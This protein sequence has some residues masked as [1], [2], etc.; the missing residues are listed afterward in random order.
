MVRSLK[1]N[2]LPISAGAHPSFPSAEIEGDL[3]SL[4]K[5][6]VKPV[7]VFNGITP[8][9]YE[10]PF[11][12]DEPKAWRRASAWENYEQ[13]RV[14]PQAQ[15]E[16]AASAPVV[17]ADVMRMVHRL[18]KQRSVEFVVAPYLAWAQLVYLERHDRAY[19]HSMYGSNELFMFDGVDRV[20]LNID[21]ASS[22]ISFA[23]KTSILA[24]LVVTHDQFLDIAIFA[25]FEGSPT[26]PPLAT[27][28]RD[29]SFQHVVG[30]IK[31]RASGVAAVTAYK[32]YPPVFSYVD[33]FAR[34]K[35]MI[36]Y[37]LVLVAQEGRVLPLPLVLPPPAFPPTSL[38]TTAADVPSDLSE[39]FS[40]HFP[41]EVYYQLF[42][43]LIGPPVLNP[44]ASGYLIESTPLCGSTPEYE[45]YLKNL[46][47]PTQSPRCVAT[48]LVSSVLSPFW[49]K[50]PVVR[51]FFP[52]S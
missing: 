19:V 27:E 29:F 52:P 38:I 9:D 18:F 23:S 16:F 24:D 43:G 39:I 11:G 15:Q 20:I 4:E 12:A 8:K 14:F 22:T 51:A 34:A 50:R 47:E 2:V 1:G 25:G 26:F 31:A 42:R 41:D 30:L 6:G 7:F 28:P 10:R 13:G 45:V 46:T 40:P 37:A 48:A 49:A 17:P 5:A 35:C 44:L 33:Q 32:D 3:K 36:K 21:F